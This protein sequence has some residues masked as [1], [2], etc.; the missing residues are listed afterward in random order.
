M[1]LMTLKKSCISPWRFFTKSL[2]A[3]R[4]AL[5]DLASSVLI[6]RLIMGDSC[7]RVAKDVMVVP[8]SDGV[9]LT[10]LLEKWSQ[11]KFMEAVS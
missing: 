3:E 2:P 5:P 9:P 1:S 7:I 4:P 8:C 10:H 6:S 11:M